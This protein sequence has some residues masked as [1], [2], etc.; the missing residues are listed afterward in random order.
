MLHK[1]VTGLCPVVGVALSSHVCV[2]AVTHSDGLVALIGLE[3]LLKSGETPYDLRVLRGWPSGKRSTVVSL[4]ASKTK[5][6]QH[7]KP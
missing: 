4:L 3:K 2:R 1:G 6:K 7:K 5:T